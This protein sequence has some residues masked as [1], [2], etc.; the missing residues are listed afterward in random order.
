MQVQGT[1][2][3]ASRNRDGIK[4][5]G[6]W[7]NIL[8]GGQCPNRGDYVT[9]TATQYND[10]RTYCDNL[11]ATPGNG[12]NGGGYRGGRGGQRG[13][14]GGGGNRQRNPR[15]VYGPIIGHNLLIAAH[16]LGPGCTVDQ[17]RERAKEITLMSERL[18]DDYVARKTGQGA[19][20][21]APQT[22][23]APQHQQPAPQHQA[24]P[25]APPAPPQAPQAQAQNP[26]NVPFDDDIPW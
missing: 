4:V 11:Q 26:A 8:Q 23:P 2:E 19:P 3:A 21:G 22:A 24:P 13:G 12:G 25:A 6:Q 20:A 9:F 10:G 14:G 7:Y 5:N 18:V 15:D 1:V 16:T 17:L